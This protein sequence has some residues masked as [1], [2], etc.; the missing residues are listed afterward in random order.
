MSKKVLLTGAGFTHNFG[1]P[2]ANELWSK[3]VNVPKL[4]PEIRRLMKQNMDYEDLYQEI[5]LAR[6]NNQ[7]TPDE[8]VVFK[9]AVN[10]AYINMDNDIRHKIILSKDKELQSIF[11][12]LVFFLCLFSVKEKGSGWI[13]T[14]NQDLFVERLTEKY[15]D[16][17]APF[18][19]DS[20]IQHWQS[21][22]DG[23]DS[24]DVPK[25]KQCLE[26]QK[27]WTGEK[28]CLEDRNLPIYVKLHGSIDWQGDHGMIIGNNKAERIKEEPLLKACF[29]KFKEVLKQED[30]ELL[31][32][33]Y[34]FGDKH[35]ND[36]ILE[37]IENYKLKIHIVHPKSFNDWIE[38]IG[39]KLIKLRYSHR[40]S[41]ETVKILSNATQGYYQTGLYQLLSPSS[42][43]QQLKSNFFDK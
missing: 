10:K 16:R 7:Y 20:G 8:R 25:E 27:I 14:L 22:R 9:E 6:N 2:L 28:L 5:V 35:I 12:Q 26:R 1:A 19:M 11:D 43:W 33:G 3:I 31:I 39:E 24:V 38:K 29:D 32:I 42:D 21:D 36:I 41:K 15:K 4:S 37:S 23:F 17:I 30:V 40:R 13:F 34:G 18:M